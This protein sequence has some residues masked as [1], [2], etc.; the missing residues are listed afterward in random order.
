MNPEDMYMQEQDVRLR[1]MQTQLESGQ[2]SN[3]NTQ[4]Y[5]D[6]QE[7]SMIKDQ[8]DLG[9]ELRRIEH[10]LKGEVLVTEANGKQHWKAPENND[11][12]ILSEYGIHLILNTITWYINKN[13]LL[14]NYSE[15]TIMEKMEDFATA[16]ADVVFMEYEKVFEYPSF[17][18]CKKILMK[19]VDTKVKLKKFSYE[20]MGD[21][22]TTEREIKEKILASMEGTIEKEIEK[23]KEQ[24]IKNKLKRFE[25]LIREI[26]DAVHST[27]LRALFG[28]ERRT[29]REHIH[30]SETKGLN[31]QPLNRGGLFSWARR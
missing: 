24:I 13:T 27:Y 10:L 25:I 3:Q 2:I 1:G 14:S 28:A 31:N 29:L 30:I 26:Q 17:D 11:M 6:E 4:M 7:K 20:L 12:V 19:R 16:L 9:D 18:D 21:Q 22:Q 23:V 5:L 15:A 8:L